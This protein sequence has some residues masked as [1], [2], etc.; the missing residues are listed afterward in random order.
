MSGTSDQ[1][2]NGIP[3]LTVSVS[4]LPE[5]LAGESLQYSAQIPAANTGKEGIKFLAKWPRAEDPFLACRHVV[6]AC[7]KKHKCEMRNDGPT[8]AQCCRL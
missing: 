1:E 3:D 6:F 4:V 8:S 5:T 2:K 7:S